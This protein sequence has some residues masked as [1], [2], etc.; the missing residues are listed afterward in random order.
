MTNFKDF[1]LNDFIVNEIVTVDVE[2]SKELFMYITNTLEHYNNVE[3][4]VKQLAKFNKKG[5][6]SS[7]EAVKSYSRVVDTAAKA[8]TKEYSSGKPSALFNGATKLDV[9]KKLEKEYMEDVEDASKV[10]V[11]ES[12]VNEN[13]KTFTLNGAGIFFTNSSTK[14]KAINI[15]LKTNSFDEKNLADQLDTKY[16]TISFQGKVGKFDAQNAYNILLK[17][18]IEKATM[19]DANKF[20]DEL[21]TDIDG[22]IAGLG[23]KVKRTN[24][25][26]SFKILS[27]DGLV[28]AYIVADPQNK[29]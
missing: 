5:T 22:K 19:D 3:K 10:G 2:A 7:D 12:I 18:D 23:Y 29:F 16:N 27:K 21:F 14:D 13:S 28:T 1:I 6:Y 17:S 25:T 11:S 26:N 8:Y 9:A 15:L 4:V 20:I 24:S